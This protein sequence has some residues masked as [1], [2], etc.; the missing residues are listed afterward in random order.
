MP[1]L[2]LPALRSCDDRPLWIVDFSNFEL[3][4]ACKICGQE[5]PDQDVYQS[6]GNGCGI[7]RDRVKHVIN[8]MLH[9]QREQQLWYA[10][11]RDD[12]AVADR[13]LVENEMAHSLPKLVAGL[14][15]LQQNSS[16][17]QRTGARVFFSCMAAAIQ[18]CGTSAGG[19]PKHDGWIFAGDKQQATDVHNVFEQQ[20]KRITGLHLPVKTVPLV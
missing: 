20:A 10:R 1:T 6:L 2:V 4:I 11:E 13:P 8:P 15:R 12:Q 18:L 19:V 5:L 7:S 14:D 17:L 16:R 9:G 3:R